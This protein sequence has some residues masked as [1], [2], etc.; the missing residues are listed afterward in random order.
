MNNLYTSPFG[1]ILFP[2]IANYIYIIDDIDYDDYDN[3]SD[4]DYIEL[5]EFNTTAFDSNN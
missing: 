2:P 1:Y 5:D 3:Y 4:V